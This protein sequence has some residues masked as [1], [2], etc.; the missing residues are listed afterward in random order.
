MTEKEFCYW[1][2]GYWELSTEDTL[3]KEQIGVIKEHLRTVFDKRTTPE[4][5]IMPG[6]TDLIC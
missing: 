5:I 4:D 3:T 1:L 2:R 6:I